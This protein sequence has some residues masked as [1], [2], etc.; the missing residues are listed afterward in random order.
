MVL[1]GSKLKVLDNSGAK[2][3]KCIGL[4][5]IGRRRYALAGDVI[6]VSVRSVRSERKIEKGSVCKA[7]VVTV[8]KGRRRKGGEQVSFN[9]NAV[10]LVK[11][12]HMP[13]G[14]RVL[15][16]VMSELRERGLMKVISLSKVTI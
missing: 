15:G 16:G 7:V 8:K 3:V 6:K 10:V 12:D 4:L 14:T 5:G 11:N 1:V 13:L 2:E 9:E